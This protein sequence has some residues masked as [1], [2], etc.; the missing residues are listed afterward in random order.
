M[1]VYLQGDY[2]LLGTE[3]KILPDLDYEPYYPIDYYYYN[4][5][6]HQPHRINWEQ[7]HS[8][9]QQHYDWEQHQYHRH[10]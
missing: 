8:Q 5:W 2:S 4:N 6:E 9:Q 10:H 7:Q 1:H 3:M